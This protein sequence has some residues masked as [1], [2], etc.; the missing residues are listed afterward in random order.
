V[1]G[2]IV[3]LCSLFLAASRLPAADPL[4]QSAGFALSLDQVGVLTL[5]FY[6]ENN[7]KRDVD[8]FWLFQ[9]IRLT[10]EFKDSK[11]YL[12][13]SPPE[14]KRQDSPRL[15]FVL[16]P[17]DDGTLRFAEG[18]LL[19]SFYFT[20]FEPAVWK[21]ADKQ[22]Q[23]G[24]KAA[25]KTRDQRRNF[26]KEGSLQPLPETFPVPLVE[27]TARL[28]RNRVHEIAPLLS[29]PALSPET[30]DIIFESAMNKES[31]DQS[32][33]VL[34]RLAAHPN[35]SPAT[36]E[37]LFALPKDPV[38]WRGIAC[39]P[40]SDPSR[41]QEYLK[42]IKEGD[43]QIRIQVARDCFAPREAWEAAL[44][45]GEPYVLS[46]FAQ[47]PK[48]PSD[49]LGKIPQNTGNSSELA[50]NPST[51]PATL[52]ELSKSTDKQVLWGLLANPSAPPEAVTTTLQTLAASKSANQR[53]TAARDARL[54]ANLASVLAADSGL[55][56]RVALAMNE[57]VSEEVS[58]K[59]SQDP[60]RLVAERA[61]ENLH[62]RFPETYASLQDGW[63]A[64]D[65]LNPHDSLL[66]EFTDAVKAGNVKKAR[67]I[68]TSDDDLESRI[69]IE[70][71][72]NAILRDNFD[73][74][75]ELLAEKIKA[76]GSAGQKEL[77][78]NSN[79]KPLH[80]EWMMKNGFLDAS[81]AGRLAVDSS[82]RNRLDL[83]EALE[84][85]KLL[86]SLTQGEKNTGLSMS[87][88]LRNP[89]LVAIWLRAGAES[90]KPGPQGI[91]AL[92]LAAKTYSIGI[93]KTLDTAGKYSQ[94]IADINKE[95]PPSPA[96]PYL[97]TWSNKRD[98]F[99]T[100]SFVLEGDGTG[101]LGVAMGMLPIL[102]KHLAPDQIQMVMIDPMHMEKGPMKD[103]ALEL[104]Y[105]AEKKAFISTSW[106]GNPEPQV[107]FRVT[108][109]EK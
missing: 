1:I 48:A 57:S 98:G 26:S 93:L 99:N 58:K 45:P 107:F 104:R 71:I 103:K 76:E 13:Q 38:V 17:Q 53:S 36:Q 14:S 6:P 24:Y 78:T 31:G 2:K 16:V 67:E 10:S 25:S 109:S 101:E 89:K 61:R 59:L 5:R 54:P 9:E 40:K 49:M 27:V 75:Q 41:M 68:L 66:E 70:L 106:Q 22:G 80:L 44:T 34:Q 65:Q 94:L 105:D 92:D 19:E 51:P 7:E 95:Y 37:K 85:R 63:T 69:S 21:P 102:W 11:F 83:V 90:D 4:G 43:T 12:Y 46:S 39:N 3:L 72:I 73:P 79:L 62:K 35:V 47:N 96:S 42:R 28:F 30:L 55:H 50:R 77:N 18:G 20:W 82:Q 74:F 29:F 23:P 15:V 64:L 88:A 87:V 60:Y 52:I 84:K 33:S 86:Q 108:E 97:G 56:V 91:S 8:I 81:N 32:Y 100:A